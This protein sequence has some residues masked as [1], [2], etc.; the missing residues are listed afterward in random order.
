MKRNSKDTWFKGG[1]FEDGYDFGDTTRTVLGTIGDFGLGA[2]KG[3]GRMVEGL[4]DLGTYGVAGV[5]DL[6][7]ADEFAD[8]TRK[9]AQYSATDEW[10]KGATDYV[11]Q[12]SVL[13]NK[14]DM[15]S[16]G[17]GQVLAIL[18]TGGTAGALA[19]GGAAGAAA[20]TAATTALTGLSG[21]GSGMNEAYGSGASDGE[22]VAFGVAQGTID[23]VSEL[24]FG[25]LGKG[26]KALGVS[27]GLTSI[28]D[29][30]ARRLSNA[31][32][33]YITSE[34]GQRVVGNTLEYAFKSGAEGLE[35]VIAGFGTAIAKDAILLNDEDE[36]A[37]R[38]ILEN[39]NLLE[40]FVVGSIVSG[41][42][43]GSDF[44]KTTKSGRDFVTGLSGSEQ[45][46]VDK[47]F[48]DTVTQR[49]AAGEKLTTKEK[50]NL[51]DTLVEQAKKGA[52]GVEQTARDVVSSVP[53]TE[54]LDAMTVESK[55]YIKTED[56]QNKQS[57]IPKQAAMDV[58][59]NKNEQSD[60]ES[61][62][63]QQQTSRAVPI[64]MDTQEGNTIS[65]PEQS[66]VKTALTLA[67]RKAAEAAFEA[68]KANVPRESVKLETPEQ[69]EAYNAGRMEHIKNMNSDKF[70]Q[71]DVEKSSDA[72][73]NKSKS[74]KIETENK[75]G[76]TNNGEYTSPEYETIKTRKPIV[77]TDFKADKQRRADA[78]EKYGL[79]TNEAT[80]LVRYVG[81]PLCY[82]LNERMI[83]GT[84]TDGDLMIADSI[85]NALLRMPGYSGHTYRNLRFN[86]EKQYNDFLS[87]Y[88]EGN[89]VEL[90]AF[91][92]TSKLP[93]GYPLFGNNVVHLVIDGVSGKDIADTFGLPR[94]QEVIYLPGTAVEIKKVMIA[95][96]GKP[97]I[98]AQEVERN[99]LIREK[100]ERSTVNKRPE[101]SV[102]KDM[103]RQRF[104]S[105]ANG[106]NRYGI[107][108]ETRSGDGR[109]VLLSERGKSTEAGNVLGEYGGLDNGQMD[110]TSEERSD[111]LQ[112]MQTEKEI[113]S[114]LH[115]IS[116]QHTD[117]SVD[118][119]NT[120]QG[121]R[122]DKKIKQAKSGTEDSKTVFV[123]RRTGEGIKK[124]SGI[125]VGEDTGYSL[126]AVEVTDKSGNKKT[127]IVEMT[128]GLEFG[129]GETISEALKTAK[130][131]IEA[132]GR[133]RIDSI[134]SKR[135]LADMQVS[136]V[137]P[138]NTTPVRGNILSVGRAVA[139]ADYTNTLLEL[140]RASSDDTI[141]SAA[142]KYALNDFKND[143]Q[144]YRLLGEI[145]KKLGA[146][147]D[148]LVK[149]KS[150]ALFGKI[151]NSISSADNIVDKISSGIEFEKEA[152]RNRGDTATLAALDYLER[153]IESE[154]SVISVS[155]MFSANKYTSDNR[156]VA[157][158][159]Y[160]KRM[161][162]AFKSLG[163]DISV[164]VYYDSSENAQRGEWSKNANGRSVI[165]LNGS[166]LQG[167]QSAFWVLS[168]ELFHEAEAKSAGI[169]Q[170]VFNVFAEMG[171]YSEEQFE[172]YKERYKSAYE[173]KYKGRLDSGEITQEE[174]DSLVRDYVNEEIVSDLMCETMGSTELLEMFTGKLSKRDANVIL[175]F[176]K[177]MLG[178]IKRPFN[179]KDAFTNKFEGVIAQ[180]EKAVKSNVDSASDTGY[181]TTKYKLVNLDGV[182]VFSPYNESGSDT[183]ERAV[184]WAHKKD[185]ND[186]SQRI[187]YHKNIRYL[188]EKDSSLSL[189]YRVLRKVTNKEYAYL[190]KL[191]DVR[192]AT[193]EKYGRN[194]DRQQGN[195]RGVRPDI[196]NRE[197]TKSSYR[198]NGNGGTIDKYNRKAPGTKGM[199]GEQNTGRRVDFERGRTSERGVEDKQGEVKFAL[200][201]QDAYLQEDFE[202]EQKGSI[203]SDGSGER[204]YSADS[205]RKGKRLDGRT[206]RY[207]ERRSTAYER[208]EY[209]QALK[210]SGAIEQKTVYGHKC[211]VIP[212]EH[213]TGR[214]KRL[215]AKNAKDGID[216]T[217]FITGKAAL[218]FLRDKNGRP[219]TAKGIFIKADGKK[220]VV[221]Q[222][223]NEFFM[224]EQINDHE[225]VHDRYKESL[226]VKV[227]SILKNSISAAERRRIFERLSSDYNGIIEGNEEKI[228][229]EFVAD[230]LSGMNE[231][232]AVFNDLVSAYWDG[233]EAFIDKFEVSRYT[234]SIDAGG[235]AEIRDI[236]N[237]GEV[238]QYTEEQYRDFVWARANNILNAGQNADYRSKFAAVKTG[239]AKFNKSK[240]GEY[241]IPVSDIYDSD[242][243]GV[244]NVLVFAKGTID[245][246][247]ITSIIEIYGY[248]E[249]EIDRVRRRIYDSERRGVQQKAGE[250]FGRYYS[251]DFEFRPVQQGTGSES[252]GN[253]GNNGF[254]GRST[255]E[256]EN[257][258]K[259][260]AGGDTLNYRGRTAA[261]KNESQRG[262]F[263]K[264]E[265]DKVSYSLQ[266]K[267]HTDLSKAQMKTVMEWLRRAGSPD[268][269]KITDTAYW[270]KGRIGG[271]DLFVIYSAEDSSGPTIL[272]EVKGDKAKFE[273]DILIDLLEEEGYGESTY[274][275]SSFA[276]GVSEGNWLQNVDS[277]KNNIRHLGAGSNNQNVGVLQRQPK[278]NGSR[279]FRN[280][281]E[282][283]FR[284]SDNGGRGEVNKKFAL[285]G[286]SASDKGYND[287]RNALLGKHG[288][289]V[290]PPYSVS[291]SEA[292]EISTRWAHKKDVENYS[293]KIVSY[294][295]QNY[296]IEKNS[297]SE[298]GY[299]VVKK[300]TKREYELFVGERKSNDT[301]Q[302]EPVLQGQA[303]HANKRV[304][305]NDK[306]SGNGFISDN[307]ANRY[308]GEISSVRGVASE[309]NE[310]EHIGSN[311]YRDNEQNGE[312]EQNEVKFALSGNVLTGE[313]DII[314]TVTEEASPE[315]Y[316]SS[317]AKTLMD[318]QVTP[319]S[320]LSEFEKSILEG[321]MTYEQ[322]TDKRAKEYAEERI[323][324]LG[325]DE[326]MREWT[327]LSQA[328]KIGKK[329]IALGMTLYNQ[330]ITNGDVKSAM[331]IAAELASEATR[332]GQ[333][334]QAFKLIKQMSPDGQL[335]YLEKSVQRMNEEF[336]ERIGK[337]YKDIK[338]D[339]ELMEKFFRAKDEETRKALYDEICYDI[340]D[341]IPSTLRD[342]W[343]SWRY[344]V[345][346][347]NFRT[348]FRN[349]AGN[350]VFLPAVRIKNYVG[351]VIEKMFV[352]KEDRTK[353]FRK[354]RDAI[355][356]AKID[357]VKMA[358]V[359]QGTNAKYATTEDIESKRKF[360]KN[361]FVEFLRKKNFD[362]LEAEDM[363]FLKVHYVDALARIIT[364]RDLDVDNIDDRILSAIRMY[365]V[366]E[367]QAATYRDANALADALN[368][369]QSFLERSNNKALRFAGALAEGVMPFK[370]TPLN[371]A[372]QGVK[373]SPISILTGVYKG[374][375][376]LRNGKA[377][378]ANEVIEDFAKGLTGTGILLLGFL[379]ARLGFIS[380]SEDEDKKKKQ[381]DKMVGEQA[382]SLNIGEHT[383]TIDWLTPVCM[384]LFVG[385]KLN[386][387]LSE[388]EELD[389]AAV[390]D[391][392]ST[393]SEPL[394][395]LSVFSGINDV[396]EATRYN[397]ANAFFA[398]SSE[399]VS[400]YVLQALPTITGQISRIADG[401]KRNYYYSDKNS[402]LPGV[403]QRF[404]GRAASKIPF[405]S[406][407]FEPSIDAWGREEDYGNIFERVV[408][409][410][411]SPGYYSKKEYTSV[412]KELY[413]LYERTRENAVFPTVQVKYYVSDG[414][415]Y[416]MN[417]EDYTEAKRIRGQKSFELVNA[418][419]RDK[420]VLPKQKK[421]YSRMSDS[422]KVAALK[423]C[424]T[425]AGMHTKQLMFDKVRENSN[426]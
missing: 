361:K 203:L 423:K 88:S 68:G 300:L 72:V 313:S 308:S 417:A 408:E 222:Y 35:E 404:L 28:D 238:V 152:A 413:E 59:E 339:E 418:L 221:V 49:E 281:V 206:S 330:C 378:S 190:Q 19:G 357:F 376:K 211:E 371:I 201:G 156:N 243:E 123:A 7:G 192:S 264:E 139:E 188:V 364:A 304:G 170:R 411:F 399:M 289:R 268:A 60:A 260:F 30:L 275:Q 293:Q 64:S 55:G 257:N 266:D 2:V 167:E 244:N 415:Y 241:I 291:K 208:R 420:I 166:K 312:V 405:A 58:V 323:S 409:N 48:E 77:A 395:E 158:E 20:A 242:F 115:E 145:A 153:L 204:S 118:T 246:P 348:H 109:N 37:F 174:Y 154:G 129:S 286:N 150:K 310:W 247:I 416:Y 113:H 24:I 111:I 332:A 398:I 143:E 44:V 92:S 355:R 74:A 387:L 200:P 95:N 379:L 295:N 114:D 294:H 338:F 47:V 186:Y 172:A 391:A 341:Q 142:D 283:L 265:N 195:V 193:E 29:V 397:E 17:V 12:Y 16:E 239:N 393:I 165:R 329:D 249:T 256:I 132:A 110:I 318:S 301:Y 350:A 180:F 168:H 135:K 163:L 160:G 280:V 42:A 354:S 309:Q 137:N 279:A 61:T 380:G 326:A 258:A 216:E 36:K 375:A 262:I 90:K 334:V 63:T 125:V 73:Y 274:G 178:G 367:A 46:A 217:I 305:Q 185:I 62:V 5:A 210:T 285:S 351:A 144:R 122:G 327:I 263:E 8:K 424:Y 103:D 94:Q 219:K 86:T 335:Y 282:N 121:V 344:L 128:S 33:K 345:M 284:I 340:A 382:Y 13:G 6:F 223:D 233:N 171:M 316:I 396:L 253:S 183:N 79:S 302:G 112:Q 126:A 82:R 131:N 127:V 259:V 50:N 39:E 368:R 141:R 278:G 287:E 358:G 292:N 321:N 34:A 320:S 38:E 342:K 373:Y 148:D 99:E 91:T 290:F 296:I 57:D 333:T 187:F 205:E 32:A 66:H 87:E 325:F 191:N 65:V 31:A 372:K 98:F 235:D 198:G 261:N 85:R 303:L 385:V 97:L 352:S 365:A 383:Y 359:L 212:K 406:Y 403:L 377:F 151:V 175:S 218:P 297:N 119:E 51:Y 299:Y 116:E 227:R 343:D 270:Y 23:A 162:A 93:N 254:R 117:R 189:G 349:I 102:H 346:L 226:A 147:E 199:G 353:S 237:D 130:E 251:Y 106:G 159:V 76:I 225:K 194:T 412:D 267:W 155:E 83:S 11:D 422:E 317:F 314:D 26:V 315:K 69:E 374:F 45:T 271:E 124:S 15:V 25:G 252:F 56:M 14:A 245:K 197:I 360:F 381:F 421:R 70:V 9:V 347:G 363:W 22:A 388:G 229:E 328:G 214:M 272:Y 369:G 108:G 288:T 324:Y 331:K 1:A 220:I 176:F 298:L 149:S 134:L 306:N 394:L 3:V 322:V 401:T 231:Y 84:L 232:T 414:I 120:L 269:K 18:A 182:K 53:L 40:Q 96:D 276:Q 43:Q 140:A 196:K 250:L 100:A 215:E 81:G 384:P 52:I 366:N 157:V 336:R 248:N 138:G 207:R 277:G 400:S 10:T 426:K 161:E 410:S 71:N 107:S 236:T 419:L 362:F 173:K 224:P 386:E 4:V 181:D 89:M 389:A 230:V 425:L 202:N 177:R 228:F 27:K 240:N 392:V 146:T 169:T 319:D 101:T 234:E 311:S 307:S 209:C 67:E 356:F 213:Y 75:N 78:A 184:R 41:I 133:E 136:S 80:R 105:V 104:D 337:R 402:I 390:F 21:M 164:S 370:K 407:L 273:R 179:S 255:K 54:K